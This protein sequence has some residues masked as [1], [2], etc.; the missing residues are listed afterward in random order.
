MTDDT[1]FKIALLEPYL[2]TC[3]VLNKL[4]NQVDFKQW[5]LINETVLYNENLSYD[6]DWYL[7]M[8]RFVSTRSFSF[9]LVIESFDC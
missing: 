3:V 4:P 2:R 5:L 6:T 1:C 7:S 8:S 9:S